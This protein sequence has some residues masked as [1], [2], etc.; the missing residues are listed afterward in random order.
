MALLKVA[1]KALKHAVDKAKKENIVAMIGG[2]SG[3]QKVFWETLRAVSDGDSRA[4]TVALQKFLDTDA[5]ECFTPKGN[6][7]AAAKHFTQV[8]CITR[9]RPPGAAEAVDS[10]TRR[11]TRTYLDAPIAKKEVKEALRIM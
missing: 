5:V 7:D 10:V 4:T 8:Y 3:G 2:F 6:A 9:E 1:R 11:P